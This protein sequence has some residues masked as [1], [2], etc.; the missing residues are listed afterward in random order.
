M[1]LLLLT[2][3]LSC[4]LQQTACNSPC[5][6]I[7]FSGNNTRALLHY[8]LHATR[9]SIL[10]LYGWYYHIFVIDNWWCNISGC[11]V[12]SYSVISGFHLEHLTISSVMFLWLSTNGIS[13]IDCVVGFNSFVS[14]FPAA[15]DFCVSVRLGCSS[16]V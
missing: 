8:F 10:T 4:K 6:S 14:L 13:I 12:G 1:N 3:G 11:V 15:S 5:R 16:A 9:V 7:S 2:N